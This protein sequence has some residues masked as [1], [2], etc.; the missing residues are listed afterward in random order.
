MNINNECK[1]ILTENGARYL[2]KYHSKQISQFSLFF[3]S[4]DAVSDIT[5]V[6]P[7]NYREGDVLKLPLWEL[8]RKFGGYFEIYTE[9]VFVNNEI[10]FV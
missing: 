3:E 5:K 4:L 7:T 1:V 9:A 8:M 2:N 10:E 6:F